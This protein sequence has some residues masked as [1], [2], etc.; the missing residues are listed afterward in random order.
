MRKQWKAVVIE[1]KTQLLEHLPHHPELQPLLTSF[2]NFCRKYHCHPPSSKAIN[3]ASCVV[4]EQ[5][6]YDNLLQTIERQA[7]EI[8]ALDLRIKRLL[9]PVRKNRHSSNQRRG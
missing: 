4:V 8:D 7:E 3:T 2:V 5:E 6:A 1:L 9:E